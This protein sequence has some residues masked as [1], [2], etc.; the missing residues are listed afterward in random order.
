MGVDGSGTVCDG[1]GRRDEAGAS[2]IYHWEDVGE[3]KKLFRHWCAWVKAIR[4]RTGELLEPMDRAA[5][6][7]EGHLEGLLAH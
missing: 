3:S 5:R 6:M 1:Y 2:R 7:I 4:E